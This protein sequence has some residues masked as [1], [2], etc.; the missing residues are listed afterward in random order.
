MDK[1]LIFLN[2]TKFSN[3]ILKVSENL[4]I[5][6]FYLKFQSRDSLKCCLLEF[7]FDHSSYSK[8]IIV[9]NYCWVSYWL[10]LK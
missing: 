6:I 7:T 5:Y 3:F 9:S 10:F 4:D 1:I 8:L 2:E